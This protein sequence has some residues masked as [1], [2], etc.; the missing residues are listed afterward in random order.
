M[1]IDDDCK[2][3]HT[4]VSKGEE[5]CLYASNEGTCPCTICI[6]KPMCNQSCDPFNDYALM[7]IHVKT[8]K[9][10]SNLVLRK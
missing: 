9:P 1:P 5:Q 3:C 2:S 8:L 6:V 7:V 10:S 4:Q